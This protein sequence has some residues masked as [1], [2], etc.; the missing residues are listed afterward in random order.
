MEPWEDTSTQAKIVSKIPI[1]TASA[2]FIVAL[3]LALFW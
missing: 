2:I 1:I 3:C